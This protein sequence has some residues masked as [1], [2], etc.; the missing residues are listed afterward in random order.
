MITSKEDITFYFKSSFGVLKNLILQWNSKM[1]KVGRALIS[2]FCIWVGSNKKKSFLLNFFKCYLYADTCNDK[3]IRKMEMWKNGI[4]SESLKKLKKHFF[5]YV[6]LSNGFEKLSFTVI[7]FKIAPTNWI[8]L[9]LK[10]TFF[11]F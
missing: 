3:N 10:E 8:W 7:A 11:L 2:L 5:L 1:Y 9:F 4:K 6:L